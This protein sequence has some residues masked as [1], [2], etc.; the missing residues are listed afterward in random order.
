MDKMWGWIWSASLSNF[1][2]RKSE[3]YLDKGF[4]PLIHDDLSRAREKLVRIFGD[5]FISWKFLAVSSGSLLF[6]FIFG[7]LIESRAKEIPIDWGAT[8]LAII[9]FIIGGFTNLSSL[10]ITRRLLALSRPKFFSLLLIIVG[11]GIGAYVLM[12]IPY[13][14]VVIISYWDYNQTADIIRSFFI[15]VS[16][17]PLVLLNAFYSVKAFKFQ[18]TINFIILLVM[19]A[20]AAIPSLFYFF[21][22]FFDLFRI[23]ILRWLYWGLAG[24]FNELAESKHPLTVILGAIGT[25][26]PLGKLF[27]N[28][29]PALRNLL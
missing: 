25:L 10:Y 26:V 29:L 8:R 12:A 27:W 24:L 17:W 9:Q 13:W 15:G 16:S 2:R 22:L 14:C 5:R 21:L 23:S 28:A 20:G 11:D 19:F 18:A 4:L 7:Q 1:F 6:L 3:K